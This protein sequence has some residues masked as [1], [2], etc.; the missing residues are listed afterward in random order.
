[1]TSMNPI[2]RIACGDELL[3]VIVRSEFV[4]DGVEFFTPTTFSQQLGYMNHAAGH[5][6]PAHRH[7]PA[8]RHIE[9]TN[10][11]LFV[12]SGSVRV[13]LYNS[14]EDYVVSSLLRAGDVILLVSGGHG[15]RMLERTEMVEVKQGPYAGDEDKA[16]IET[17]PENEVRLGQS[18]R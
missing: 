15:F 12:K 2:E 5:V 3:A 10:E 1:M 9:Y 14:A 13:D 4:K 18:S 8:P 11:V 6:I 17:V 16:A 7:K